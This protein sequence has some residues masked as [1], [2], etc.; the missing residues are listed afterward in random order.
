M[1]PYARIRV[2]NVAWC[3]MWLRDP[4]CFWVQDCDSIDGLYGYGT[5]PERPVEFAANEEVFLDVP[6]RDKPSRIRV[7]VYVKAYSSDEWQE[8]WSEWLDIGSR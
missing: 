2:R 8:V 5:S 1:I 3:S 4:E 6:L 7:C